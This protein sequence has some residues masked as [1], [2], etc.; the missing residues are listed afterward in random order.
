VG[1]VTLKER[2]V[3]ASNTTTNQAVN[4]RAIEQQRRNNEQQQRRNNTN[5]DDDEEDTHV[6]ND[7]SV[8]GT[9]TQDNGTA[10][11]HA[12][13]S[14]TQDE[15]EVEEEKKSK[16]KG[17]TKSKP[18]GLRIES[19]PVEG[20]IQLVGFPS[21]EQANIDNTTESRVIVYNNESF[22]NFHQDNV[23]VNTLAIVPYTG[24]RED[25]ITAVATADNN[26]TLNHLVWGEVDANGSGERR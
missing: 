23:E 6:G 17:P 3:P 18:S 25:T 14:D 1:V 20:N 22:D 11:A 24:Y 7:G 12:D 8:H 19:V 4:S 26:I 10:Q 13:T 16:G 2:P 15:G 21:L 5:S 9:N